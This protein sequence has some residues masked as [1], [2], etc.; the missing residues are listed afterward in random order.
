MN[1]KP[2]I[3][4][5]YCST[6]LNMEMLHVYRQ[7]NNIRAFEN[8]VVTR[9]RSNSERFPYPRVE[10]LQK[11]PGRFINRALNSLRKQPYHSISERNQIQRLIERQ[12][13]KL[14]H[15]YL[16]TEAIRLLP[17]L[18]TLDI[19]KVVSFHGVDVSRAASDHSLQ[20]LFNA[21][22]LVLPR[23]LSLKSRLL[24]RSCPE[25]KIRLNYTGVPC[26]AAERSGRSLPEGVG[27]SVPLRLLQACRFVEKKGLD[28]SLRTARLLKDRGLNVRL[29]LIGDGLCASALR[30]LIRAENLGDTVE[31][32]PFLE[33]TELLKEFDNHDLFIQPSRTTGRGDREGIPNAILEA[34]GAGLPVIATDHSGIPEAIAHNVNGW[35]VK[36]ANETAF[37]DA[38]EQIL[39]LPDAYAQ[40]S[41]RAIS[42]IHERFSIAASVK[43]LESSYG[44]AIRMR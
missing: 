36:A 8:W 37:G 26:A 19:A 16:G 27:K 35:L 21:V 13:A 39:K 33:N 28:V 11:S 3:C 29:T 30:S 22:D 32:R 10:S 34:M 15:V 12:G 38:L 24:E 2:P 41:N 20:R 5:S 40:V 9:K 14:L 23:S 17:L 1:Q 25:S 42:T 18:E 31:I 7:I 6:F 43:A 44:E 4:I